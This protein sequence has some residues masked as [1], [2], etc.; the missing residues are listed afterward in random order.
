VKGLGGR[1]AASPLHLRWSVQRGVGP[2]R[3]EQSVGCCP[4]VGAVGKAVRREKPNFDFDVTC[5][6]AGGRVSNFP[7]GCEGTVAGP[8]LTVVFVEGDGGF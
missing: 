5:V 8:L 6:V 2:V 4:H 3:I 1:L 7:P